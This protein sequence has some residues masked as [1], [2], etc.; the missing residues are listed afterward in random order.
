VAGKIKEKLMHRKIFLGSV[1][2][3]LL[4]LGIFSWRAFSAEKNNLALVDLLERLK[5][6]NEESKKEILE[7]LNQILANQQEM[8]KTLE[9]L[10]IRSYR[11][12]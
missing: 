12:N 1:F 11:G 3:L 2:V 7:K 6:T 5:L 10:K 8:Q 4:V 9:F